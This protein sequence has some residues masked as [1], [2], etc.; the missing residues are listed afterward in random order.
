MLKK[1]K[2]PE[3]SNKSVDLDEHANERP[4][5]EDNDHASEEE[6]RS[7]EFE[8]SEKELDRALEA[9]YEANTGDE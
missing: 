9:D 7:F 3:K 2:I 4:T 5:D 8:R 1:R 6:K